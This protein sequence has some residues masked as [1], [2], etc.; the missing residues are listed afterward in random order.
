MAYAQKNNIDNLRTLN[1]QKQ[2][3]GGKI[4]GGKGIDHRGEEGEVFQ[5]S[6]D[7]DYVNTADRWLV[8]TGA[9]EAPMKRIGI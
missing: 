3:F 7:A 5:H 8:T 2:S 1:N 4:L 9:I 6:P